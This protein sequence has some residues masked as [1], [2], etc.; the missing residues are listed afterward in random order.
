MKTNRFA[1]VRPVILATL[2]LLASSAAHAVLIAY[3]GFDYG[4]GGAPL[5]NDALINTAPNGGTGF[6]TGFTSANVNWS[7]TGLSSSSTVS[8]PIGGSLRFDGNDTLTQ[9]AWGDAT[10]ATPVGTYWYSFL[11]N[12]VDSTAPG[13]GGRG[14]FNIMYSTSSTNGQN[15]AGLRLDN[16]NGGADLQ[17]K[18]LS[19]TGGTSASII[20]VAGGYGQTYFIVGR[21]DITAGGSTNRLWVNPTDN[22]VPLDSASISISMDAT[23]T[24]TLRPSLAGR[25]FGTGAGSALFEDE[26]RIGTTV[27]DVMLIPEPS[28]AAL[29]LLGLAGLLRRRR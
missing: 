15:G 13:N 2:T 28:A 27:N 6:N 14:T 16:A 21:I 10:V 7:S 11:F 9:R 24:A 8:A 20:T 12:P 23:Q 22:M 1:F 19:S 29:G 18:A 25:M 26:V 4:T 17:F 5:A 3:D